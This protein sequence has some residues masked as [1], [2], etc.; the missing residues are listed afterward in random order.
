MPIMPCIR[1]AA[2]LLLLTLIMVSCSSGG[3]GFKI[4]GQFLN[5]NQGEFYVYSTD[6]AIEG[7]D[8]VTF[9]GGRFVRTLDCRHSGTL[10]IVFPNFSEQPI[11][12]EPGKSVTITADA[13]HLKEME[14]KGTRDNQRMTRFRKETSEMSPPDIQATAER[15]IREQPQSLVSIYLLRRYFIQTATPD[16]DKAEEL[17]SIMAEKPDKNGSIIRLQQEIALLK[18]ARIGGDIP[19]FTG[20]D[21]HGKAFESTS[22][23]GKTTVVLSVASWC[24]ES[25]NQQRALRMLNK[26][27]P[28]KLN[29]VSICLDADKQAMEKRLGRDTIPWPILFDGEMF[30]SEIVKQAGLYRI[31]DNLIADKDGHIIARGLSTA[32]LIEEL[33]KLLEE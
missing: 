28:D 5:L 22:L 23:K 32:S 31:P 12:A 15:Y 24:F 8:T 27:H 18:T 33:K 3:S 2:Y 10:M 30:E 11:F 9:D 17:V 20:I 25:M 16:Y 1:H 6:G 29:I 4:E 14:V 26:N 21:I 19:H 7:M 13:S